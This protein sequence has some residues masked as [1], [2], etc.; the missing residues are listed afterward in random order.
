M[1]RL[2]PQIIIRFPFE[3]MMYENPF[4]CLI[5][6]NMDEEA[7]PAGFGKRAIGIG[8]DMAKAVTDIRRL[9]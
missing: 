2:C 6:L 3:K 8:G 4:Y 1:I 5:R 7:V 9:V